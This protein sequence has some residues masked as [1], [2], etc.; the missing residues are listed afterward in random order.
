MCSNHGM[1]IFDSFELKKL[2]GPLG[3]YRE[4]IAGLV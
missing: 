2:R 4:T 3:V 1:H